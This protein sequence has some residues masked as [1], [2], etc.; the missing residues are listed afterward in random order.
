[1]PEEKAILYSLSDS[2]VI[3]MNSDKFSFLTLP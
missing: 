3:L 2:F 1:M